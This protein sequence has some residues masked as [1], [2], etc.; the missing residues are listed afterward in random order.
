MNRVDRSAWSN[1]VIVPMIFASRLPSL[2][3][4]EISETTLKNSASW[5]F[6]F[7][8]NS[9]KRL[10]C[11]ETEAWVAIASN[12]LRS[13]G[14]KWA[15][16]PPFRFRTSTTPMISPRTVRIG[17][18]AMDFVRYPVCSSTVLLKAGSL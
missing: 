6:S 16:L 1:R 7:S 5:A 15:S 13:F 10:R 14:T 9:I 2:I 18:Q 17:A 4:P 11:R 12:S 3:S 8:A